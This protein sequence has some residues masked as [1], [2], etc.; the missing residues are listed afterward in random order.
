MDAIYADFSEAFDRVNL[1]LLMAKLEA[2]GISGS[3]LSWLRSFL[4]NRLLVVKCNNVTSEPFH[5][6]SGVPQGSHLGPILFNIFI[7]DVKDSLS[8]RFLLFAD[9]MKLFSI[10]KNTNDAILLQGDLDSFHYWTMINCLDLNI[11]KC[12]VISFGR[13]SNPALHGYTLGEQPL[14]RVSSI[15][16]LGVILDARLN[17]KEH[18]ECVTGRACRMLGFI[19]RNCNELSPG[20]LRL[21]YCTLVRPHLEYASP[22]WSPYYSCDV[23]SLEAVQRRVLRCLAFRARIQIVNY[24]LDPIRR[25]FN[26]DYLSVRRTVSDLCLLYGMLNGSVE[27]DLLG[28]INFNFPGRLTRNTPIFRQNMHRTNYASHFFMNRSLLRSVE[29]RRCPDFFSCTLNTFRSSVTKAVRESYCW[30]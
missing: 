12:N 15:K 9:D 4:Y 2:V 21:L 18:I 20:S 16:D 27:S 17:F 23:N 10:I 19:Y 6:S 13:L 14:S 1:N 26:V 29:L 7:D 28:L 5:V 3:L 25:F 24:D 8:C 22:V 11:D 30:V